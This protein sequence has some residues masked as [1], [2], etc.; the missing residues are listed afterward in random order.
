MNE[1][2]FKLGLLLNLPCNF[3]KLGFELRKVLSMFALGT[4]DLVL[5]L[6]TFKTSLKVT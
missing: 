6:K 3:G 1:F 2:V 4:L 5:C